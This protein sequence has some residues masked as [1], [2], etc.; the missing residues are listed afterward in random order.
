MGAKSNQRHSLG[1]RTLDFGRWTLDFAVNIP[2]WPGQRHEAARRLGVQSEVGLS[3][4][5]VLRLSHGAIFASMLRRARS[6]EAARGLRFMAL[7]LLGLAR[8]VQI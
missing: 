2:G 4:E 8:T 1:S 6:R 7:P 5:M 3:R